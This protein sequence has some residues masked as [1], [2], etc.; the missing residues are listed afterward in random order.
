MKN[1]MDNASI[2]E[3]FDWSALNETHLKEKIVKII[4]L[5]PEDTKT[6]VDVGCGNGVITNIL[7]EKY[8]VIG[9]DR[10]EHALR[11]VKTKK[12]KASSENIPLPD[13]SFDMVFS[14][15]LLEHLED[16]VLQKTIQEFERLTKKY[17]LIT[18]P[19]NE[20]PD[21]LLI[22]CPSCHYIYNSPNHLRRFKADDFIKLFPNYSLLKQFSFGK[23]VRYY[24][25]HLLN[26]KKKISPA[27]SWIPY[28]WMPENKRKTICPKCEY[29]FENRYR[30]NLFATFIDILNVLISPK[31]AYWL[32]V[33]LEKK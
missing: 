29:E 14:S 31:K 32:F 18:V 11:M 24:N 28:Y 19:N 13:H 16:A 17:I 22:K 4:E 30:F 20:N 27:Q 12:V 23:N 15:E 9:V 33:L 7:G 8:E 6:I 26:I 3:K 2:Y 21:K 25:T 1:K 10:S 5:I